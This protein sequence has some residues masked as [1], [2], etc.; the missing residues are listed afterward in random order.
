M[1]K[2]WALEQGEP[3]AIAA[4]VSQQLRG[5]IKGQ[6]VVAMAWRD[7]PELRLALVSA[8]VPQVSCIAIFW[9]QLVKLQIKSI[10]SVLVT[11]QQIG[12]TEAAW[13]QSLSLNS[14]ISAPSTTQSQT[15]QGRSSFP[16]KLF[17]RPWHVLAWASAFTLGVSASF[18]LLLN[19]A[20]DHEVPASIAPPVT[21]APP[22]F[23]RLPF[24]RFRK[25][26]I[27]REASFRLVPSVLPLAQADPEMPI[28]ETPITLKAVG[29]IIP[30]T[31]FPENRLIS[32]N[33]AALFAAIKP[34]LQG[35]DIVFGNFEST[36]T[37]YPRSA[38]DVSRGMTFAFRT[39]PSYAQ[40]L[41]TVGFTILSVANNHS[42]DFDQQG[43][44]DTMRNIEAAGMRAVGRKGQI[45]YTKV[46]GKTIAFIGFSYLDYHNSV[47]NLTAAKALI[48]KARSQADI[49]VISMHVGAEGTDATRTFNEPEIFYGENRGNSILF[50]RTMVDNGAD[51]IL[52]HGP[53]V[54]RAIELY[55]NKLIVYSLGN[56]MGYRTLS[57]VG[58]L[59]YSL[60][61]NVE[62]NDQ[63]DFLGGRGIPIY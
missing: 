53:H 28:A 18:Y 47:N 44:D 2:S 16:S 59:G 3:Q 7:G 51:L 34:S 20:R 32:G 39:P 63:G 5:Q 48:K 25:T 33:P 22:K 52:G 41:K 30:G 50:S 46:K 40:L 38:K 10:E 62:L 37:N 58:A 8:K 56:F 1:Q 55:K 57:T 9:E 6:G 21:I 60:I 13:T 42:Y 35:S 61:L 15:I 49:V 54:P 26:A 4:W 11:G 43:F 45:L 12:F 14:G 17:D 36:L 27:T 23:R 31:N 24:P 19:G 29:D